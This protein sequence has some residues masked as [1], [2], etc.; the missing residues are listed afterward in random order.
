MEFDFMKH[1]RNVKLEESPGFEFRT[2]YEQGSAFFTFG[3]LGERIKGIIDEYAKKRRLDRRS[4][5]KTASG[6][7][8]AMLAVNKV[9]G[10]KFFEVS[11]AEAIDEAAAA[12]YSTGSEFIIDMHTHVGWRK[13][14]FTKENTTER[15]MW[16]VKLLDDLGK[17]MGL[18]NGL[19]DMDVDG[20]GRLLYK[21]S[22]TA[23]AIVNMFGFRED[24]GGMDMNPIEEVAEA[25]NRWPNR[26]ILLGGGLT[27]NQGM[28]ETLER[29]D[30]F[31]KDLKISGLKLYTFDST[32]KKG[33]WF[34]DEKAY[35]LW[36]KCQKEGIKVIGCHKGIPFGQFMA[37][38]S[39]AEDLDRVADDFLD[40]NWV[41][42]HSGWPYHHEIAALKAFKPQRTNLWCEL[43]STFAATV[44]NRPIE[45]A[46]ILGTL[47]RDLGAD[48][49]LWGT[50][51][52][53]WG[54]AQWQIEAF[55]KFQIP[56]Q[57]AEGYGYPKL[58]DEIKR[59]I[60]GE[61]CAK[62]FG[63]NI[64]EKRKEIKLREA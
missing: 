40:I 15:G 60:L 31:I 35:P 39:H 4:F 12:E 50:D 49:V 18:P 37:R 25:R 34:D 5:L 43:G 13:A 3:S 28:S 42:F 47:I 33:W 10:M 48:R 64:E 32:P 61:N 22:D 45:C 63:I 24:Y 1:F 19:R 38:Y 52:P 62:L 20:F 41:A 56:D 11:E 17:S 53:L 29:L 27:I 36:E 26:T 55:R 54:K 6:F 23:M 44:T 46:H 8:A 16:F 30:H 58:T 7:A 57:L 9:S 2:H 51:S 59:K 21:E 14:G